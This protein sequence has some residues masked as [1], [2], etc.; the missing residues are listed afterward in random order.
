L[1][2]N[3]SQLWVDANGWEGM[4]AVVLVMVINYS[5][6]IALQGSDSRKER[7][8]IYISPL[9]SVLVSRGSDVDHTVLPANYTTPAFPS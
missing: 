5:V 4:V 2:T 1:L 8:S 3:N 6:E 9:Y 7:K